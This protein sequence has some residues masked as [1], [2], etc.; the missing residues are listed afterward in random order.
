[1]RFRSGEMGW[2]P[3]AW[4]ISAVLAS[5]SVLGAASQSPGA[6]QSPGAV[7]PGWRVSAGRGLAGSPLPGPLRVLREIRD[8]STGALWLIVGN[9]KSPAGP[10]R[11]LLANGEPGGHAGIEEKKMQAIIH[12]GERLVV[13]EHTAAVDAC[14]EAVALGA[15]A[16][17]S[18][19]EV[20]LKIGG[21]VMRTV[22]IAPGRATLVEA[23]EGRR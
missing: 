14:L 1:M 9:A 18:E 7:T 5:A 16:L 12:P 19:L 8:P 3:A 21:G 23:V 13:E 22:A 2:K 15:A 11:M 10:G 20:R 6:N 4:V 17:G